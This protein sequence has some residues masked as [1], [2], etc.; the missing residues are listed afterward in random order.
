MRF[1]TAKKIAVVN[2]NGTKKS[3]DDI[4]GIEENKN[5]LKAKWNYTGFEKEEPSYPQN[6]GNGNDK[7]AA[8]SYDE[9]FA[10][11]ATDDVKSEVVK[12]EV[13]K[14]EVVESEVMESDS[15]ESEDIVVD[16]DD[17]TLVES[18]GSIKKGTK[19]NGLV[20]LGF[21]IVSIFVFGG[22]IVAIILLE[23]RKKQNKK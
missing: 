19:N 15:F 22:A 17:D 3:R 9:F 11:T 16:S 2:Y 1:L 20:I 21:G 18:E 12:S 7:N 4:W 6:T 5:L 14:S 23:K 8:N 13:V 10:T